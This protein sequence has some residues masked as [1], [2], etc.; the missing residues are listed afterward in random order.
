MVCELQTENTIVDIPPVLV[1]LSPSEQTS[2][3]ILLD[4]DGNV[5]S[6]PSADSYSCQV[7]SLL[8]LFKIT[9]EAPFN[10]IEAN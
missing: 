4:N 7:W 3:A 2:D 10:G 6:R 5:V 8:R 9:F 1:P